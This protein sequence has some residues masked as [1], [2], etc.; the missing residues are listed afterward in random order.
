VNQQTFITYTACVLGAAVALALVI[1]GAY[2]Q[3]SVLAA[4]VAFLIYWAQ[5]QNRR[6]GDR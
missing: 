2:A 3:A 5:R 1:D 6:E 4:G